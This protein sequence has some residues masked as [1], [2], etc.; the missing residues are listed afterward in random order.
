MPHPSAL[1]SAAARRPAVPLVLGGLLT[2]LLASGVAWSMT[3]KT[4]LLSVDGQLQEV[5]FRGET[6]GDVL[7]AAGM[8][9]G[10]RDV[11]VPAAGSE[12]EDGERI[13]LRRA[14]LLTLVVDGKERDV[15]VTASSVDEALDQIGL[16]DGALALS[17]SRS[18]GIP[19][20]GLRL[21]VRTPKDVVVRVGAT[22]KRVTTTAAT[23]RD[24][25]FA[26]RVTLDADDRV[27]SP[28]GTPVTDG[29][30]LRVIRVSTARAEETVA[31]PFATE[32]REDANLVKGQTKTLQAGKAGVVRRTVQITYADGALEKRTVL[33]STTVSA[34]VKRVLA[35]GTKA[36]PAAQ[37]STARRSTGG[38]DSLN[39]PAL[40]RCESGG[41]P[42]AVS[43]TGKYRGLYQFSYATWNGVGGSGDPAAASA[44]EQTYRAKL[45]YNR[46][47]AG[48]WPHCGKYLFT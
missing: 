16:R 44:S 28:Q 11:L 36:R 42:R 41:N 47:G 1:L 23:V 45:L 48:Q 18:R 13:A 12:V 10:E 27:S 35:V 31:V 39:W 21:T 32:R 19:L 33:S 4:A 24:A 25:L 3:G 6:V 43:S 37:T 34:P 7:A 17:A 22:E 2:A 9:A 14:R 38:A 20:D 26:A 8:E 5:D 29:M 40:A 30:V 46:S 15:W